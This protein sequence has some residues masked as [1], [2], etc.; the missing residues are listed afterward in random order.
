MKIVLI[1][2]AWLYHK[3]NIPLSQ[4]VGLTSI[5]ASLQKE[6]HNVS[7]INAVALGRRKIAQFSIEGCSI[8]KIGLS[9]TD[10]I[11]RI[12]YD[13]DIVGI[14][15][16]FTHHQH[17]VKTLIR[18]IRVQYPQMSIVLGGVLPSTLPY[19]AAQ[20]G[21]DFIVVGEGEPALTAFARGIS[22][23]EIEGMYES[24]VL[25]QQ[26]K[27]H[28][29]LL[30]KSIVTNMNA[31]PFPARD[32]LPFE[33]YIQSQSSGRGKD[34]FGVSL[35]TSRGCP[36]SCNFCSVHSV[37]KR[38]FRARTAESVWQEMKGII[39]KYNVFHFEF[40]DDNLTLD[41]ERALS[42]FNTM[43]QWNRLHANKLTF[44]TPNGI[45]ID[46]LD[47]E[48]LA[49]MKMAGCE[50]IS[51]A[52]EHGD[53]DMLSLMHKQLNMEKVIDVVRSCKPIGI[54]VRIYFIIGYP[55]ETEHRWKNGILFMKKLK[56][57]NNTIDFSIFPAKALPGTELAEYCRKKGYDLDP[58]PDNMVVCGS[59]S[60]I[61]TPEFSHRKVQ[62]RLQVS[63]LL[64]NRRSIAHRITSKI[65]RG[66]ANMGSLS[67]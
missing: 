27:E 4:L 51:L 12:P 42:L 10:I 63:D 44:I 64:L 40:E 61:E 21:A 34:K 11:S 54:A 59:F 53:S 20:L 66:F 33:D 25:V 49:L 46:T 32:L 18:A 15:A 5:A 52:V 57:I 29:G 26:E 62:Q 9:D 65:K 8:Y 55:G 45:R 39:D 36:Y 47:H 41:R 58:D 37:F 7:L 28:R 35:H 3:R 43:A 22:V 60:N 24:S 23:V 50:R 6:G 48:L 1:N 38:G 2:P 31:L 16:P 56:K 19:R 17:V 67:Q 13:T 30:Q 14:S